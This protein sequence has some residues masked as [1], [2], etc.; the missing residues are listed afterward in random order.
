MSARREP[1]SRSHMPPALTEPFAFAVTIAQSVA[2][3]ETS[4]EAEPFAFAVTIAESQP[5][6]DAE[7]RLET[8]RLS[9]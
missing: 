5:D 8:F 4:T 7:Q 6:E 1:A 2:E 3:T 9:G